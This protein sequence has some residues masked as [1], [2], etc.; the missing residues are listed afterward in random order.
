MDD[1]V[2]ISSEGFFISAGPQFVAS[3]L[4]DHGYQVSVVQALDQFTFDEITALVDKFIVNEKQI[5]GLSLTFT[6]SLDAKK[7][8]KTFVDLAR[9]KFSNLRIVAGGATNELD[10][11]FFFPTNTIYLMGQNKEN[12]II[13]LFNRLTGRI[14]KLPFNFLDRK[15]H[16]RKIFP[17]PTIGQA[18]FLEVSKGCKFDCP[19]CSM[20]LRRNKSVFK[21]K[22]RLKQEMQEFYDVFGDHK[23][24]IN[25]VLLCNTVN[26]DEDKIKTLYEA[27]EELTFNPRFFAFTRFDLYCTQ[28]E[29][30]KAF[31]RKYV[32]YPYFG[33]E[34]F[35]QLT[36]R[37]IFKSTKVEKMKSELI[38]FRKDCPDAFIY[39]SF[40]IGLPHE[41]IESLEETCEWI[42]SSD[43]FDFINFP[44]LTINKIT[45]N[46]VEYSNIDLEPEKFGYTAFDQKDFPFKNPKLTGL[47]SYWQREDG[48]TSEDALV[49]ANAI[50]ARL[51][52]KLSYQVFMVGTARGED[53]PNY[54][55]RRDVIFS[56]VWRD[57]QENAILTRWKDIAGNFS[58]EYYGNLMNSIP[59]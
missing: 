38:E 20:E 42:K 15:I 5:L 40:V 51:N 18:M 54:K 17:N 14:K 8:M 31:Y 57:E 35:N 4:I 7:A 22:E 13:D 27:C 37:A 11:R 16:Y 34:S 12:E 39:G 23:D 9:K 53:V 1:V 36:L 56:K 59:Q 49:A 58:K 19:F 45:P 29:T 55:V 3:L 41:T 26:E 10:I 48:F 43:I 32:R 24:F 2:I 44:V 21:T 52:S 50:S 30:T 6:R 28:N 46:L 47:P 33:V 25:V